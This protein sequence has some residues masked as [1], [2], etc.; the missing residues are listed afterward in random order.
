M[1][2][3]QVL[4]GLHLGGAEQLVATFSGW[5]KRNGHEVLVA[6]LTPDTTLLH[7]FE[8]EGVSV[9]QAEDGGVIARWYP[10]R[11]IGYIRE[12]RP[13]VLHCHNTAWLKS[14]SAAR[15]TGVP[16]VFTL[17]GYHY[18][19]WF[20]KHRLW[21][22]RAARNTDYCVGVAPG[23]ERLFVDILGVLPERAVCIPNGVPDIYLPDPPPVDWKSPMPAGSPIVGMVGRF[24]LQFKDQATLI[25]AMHLVR[26]KVRNAQLV[27]V[28]D[29]PNRPNVERLATELNLQGCVHF[30]GLRQ[31]VPVLLHHLDVFVLSSRSE[32]QSIAVLEAMSA[33]RPIVATAVGGTPELLADGE[34]GLLVPPG[35]PQAMAEAITT[36]LGDSRQRHELARRARERFMAQHSIECMGR[37]YL[38]VYMTVVRG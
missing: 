22:R 6:N 3:L 18:G 16:C 35:D 34:C 23:I 5:L 24:D 26:Q 21:L 17:H 33:Q 37:A 10:R 28:G 25:R 11:L 38:E 13:D 30:L 9:V 14:A 19:A 1:R 4:A 29:G 20:R 32:G 15:W 36:L 7:A 31:D 8:R 27:L 2:V 12:F